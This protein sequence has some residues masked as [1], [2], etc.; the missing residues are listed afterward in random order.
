MT[1]INEIF[2]AFGPEYLRHFGASIPYQHRKTMEAI[3]KCAT[4]PDITSCSPLPFRRKS[5]R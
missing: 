1:T 5:D 4:S 2:R 3:I